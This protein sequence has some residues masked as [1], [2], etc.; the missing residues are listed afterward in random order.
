MPGMSGIVEIAR[1]EGGGRCRV[2]VVGVA[3][4]LDSC[5]CC[6]RDRD[7]DYDGDE[8]LIRIFGAPAN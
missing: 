1:G 8:F 5:L 2:V 3:G 7:R 6:D 4:T